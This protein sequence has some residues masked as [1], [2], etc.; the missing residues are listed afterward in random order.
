MTPLAINSLYPGLTLEIAREIIF[1][2]SHC[3]RKLS[4]ILPLLRHNN[5]LHTSSP[6]NDA[7]TSSEAVFGTNAFYLLG[8]GHVLC[9]E[10]LCPIHFNSQDAPPVCSCPLCEAADWAGSIVEAHWFSGWE[11]HQHSAFMP[12]YFRL[13]QLEDLDI[14]TCLLNALN[15]AHRASTPAPHQPASLAI[16]PVLT[17]PTP[18]QLANPFEHLP[19]PSSIVVPTQPYSVPRHARPTPHAR[20]LHSDLFAKQANRAHRVDQSPSPTTL[21][22][23][24]RPS[25]FPRHQ[26]ETELET[27]GEK[28]L[29]LPRQP[30]FTPETS[31]VRAGHA[32]PTPHPC[33]AGDIYARQMGCK[34]G[35]EYPGVLRERV[36]PTV[37][38]VGEEIPGFW[39]RRDAGLATRA[40]GGGSR[41][42]TSGTSITPVTK[43]RIPRLVKAEPVLHS[44][45]G[46][47]AKRDLDRKERDRDGWGRKRARRSVGVRSEEMELREVGKAMGLLR[48]ERGHVDLVPRFVEVDEVEEPLRPMEL[49]EPNEGNAEEKDNT[50]RKQRE[51]EKGKHEEEKCKENK[52]HKEEK[53]GFIRAEME[54]PITGIRV[55]PYRVSSTRHIEGQWSALSKRRTVKR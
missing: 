9:R 55:S 36:G 20:P 54:S 32:L 18:S 4:D 23:R 28:E 13:T 49:M 30:L 24:A 50:E 44:T 41:A 31:T 53:T 7:S 16:D 39:R 38:F 45:R 33:L 17:R 12:S 22:P 25:R 51:E 6:S 35:G 1:A 52:K 46:A 8:C 11:A 37:E 2:C 40:N 21:P 34:D 19:A 5:S 26:I 47:R 43:G 27:R 10:H 14:R 42:G 29:F 3:G 15:F 48:A